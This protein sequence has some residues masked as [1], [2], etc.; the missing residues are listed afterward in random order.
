MAAP[1]MLR[2]TGKRW[3]RGGNAG[4]RSI[5]REIGTVSHRGALRVVPG[6][7]VLEHRTQRIFDCG[8]SKVKVR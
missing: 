7:D 8:R 3:G 4:V 6:V 1:K 2:S 5:L